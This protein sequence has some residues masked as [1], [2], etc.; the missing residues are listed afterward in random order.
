M[1]CNSQLAALLL[2]VDTQAVPGFNV[3]SSM[4]N[5]QDVSSSMMPL[6]IEQGVLNIED[7]KIA[8]SYNKRVSA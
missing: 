2:C 5:F 7:L 1:A 8:S 4:L 3:Q 6:R